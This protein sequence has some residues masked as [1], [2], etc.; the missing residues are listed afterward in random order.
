M[1]LRAIVLGSC[2][3][4]LPMCHASGKCIVAVAFEQSAP[5]LHPR[6]EDGLEPQTRAAEG[7]STLP[8]EASGEYEL[9]G[10]GS[11]VQISIDQN[12]LTGYV[13]RMEQGASLT[14]F[15][16][17]TAVDGSRLSF[18]TRTVHGLRYSFAGTIVRGDAATSSQMGFYRLVGNLTTIR[19]AG[20]RDTGI[21]A[22]GRE[23]Q[24]VS[25]KSTPRLR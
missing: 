6:S 21:R 5:A 12:R 3:A 22:A 15:F 4:L 17:R 10:K 8:E 7:V 25:L 19:T 18:T 13:T 23:T 2:I 11:V 1:G 24:R 16:D 14:L 9:D 20:I